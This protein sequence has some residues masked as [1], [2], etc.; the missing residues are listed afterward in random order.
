M[1]NLNFYLLSKTMFTSKI[2]S[3]P[4]YTTS[5]HK[6][7]L[8]KIENDPVFQTMTTHK[9]NKTLHDSGELPS[10]LHIRKNKRENR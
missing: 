2:L 10:H 3:V 6:E 9:T 4:D 5:H 7:L 1:S 8:S